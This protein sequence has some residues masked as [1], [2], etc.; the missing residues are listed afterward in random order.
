MSETVV[1]QVAEVF[2]YYTLSFTQSVSPYGYFQ[3]R[4]CADPTSDPES[5]ATGW[6]AALEGYLVDIA[7]YV[8]TISGVSSGTFNPKLTKTDVSTDNVWVHS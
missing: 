4:I 3:V 5:N 1:N 2:P 7:E 6:T 8:G